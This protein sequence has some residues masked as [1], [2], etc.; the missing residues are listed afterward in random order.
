[1]GTRTFA[2]GSLALLAACTAKPPVTTAPQAASKPI[3][4]APGD[5]LYKPAPPTMPAGVLLAVLEGDPRAPGLFSVRMKVPAGFTLPPHTHP[6]DE[7]VTVIEG[8]VAVGFGD[9]I[10]REKVRSFEAG[11]Y[12]LNPPGV[13]HYVLSEQ[14]ATLQITGMGP[15]QVD[16]L[17]PPAH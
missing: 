16:F 15:W 17:S 11:S 6:S 13:P 12:Y 1:M 2:L 5:I 8:A 9:T 3:Q 14:G 4:L 7:R 10:D